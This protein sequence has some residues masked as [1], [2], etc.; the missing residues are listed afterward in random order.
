MTDIFNHSKYTKW[1][2][3]IVSSAK[4][5]GDRIPGYTEKHHII[6]KSMGGTD[7][8]DNIV[9]LS[10]KQHFVCHHL[11]TRMVN[12]EN[13]RKAWKGLRS[14]SIME[15]PNAKR[16]G[17]IRVTARLFEQIRKVNG[18]PDTPEMRA[19][20]SEAQR[21]RKHKHSAETLEKMRKTVAK[22]LG[23]TPRKY[24]MT[25]PLKPSWKVTS[26]SGQ[27]HN[28]YNLE[29]FCRHHGLRHGVLAHTLVTGVEVPPPIR[30]LKRIASER[31]K[32]I[33]WKV[34]RF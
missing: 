33:G 8:P 14:M 27:V 5:L 2:F 25:H 30:R 18:L 32:T 22:R 34:E 28:E 4:A 13:R 12:G 9:R 19:K 7:S 6:P 11:L 29:Q 10:A 17:S 31:N 24:Q 1:Y 3:S 23:K 26:P 16:L 15:A 20:K 21:N